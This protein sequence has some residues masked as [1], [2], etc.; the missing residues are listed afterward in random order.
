MER[1]AIEYQTFLFVALLYDVQRLLKQSVLRGIGGERENSQALSD[2][3]PSLI[4][5]FPQII[6]SSLILSLF[7]GLD[8][9]PH[10]VGGPGP[11]HVYDSHLRPLSYLIDKADTLSSSEGN[12]GGREHEAGNLT[13]LASVLE[14]V[15]RVGYEER[16]QGQHRAA[17]L[18]LPADIEKMFPVEFTQYEREELRSHLTVMQMTCAVYL[19]PKWLTALIKTSLTV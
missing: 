11:G 15:N 18:G 6:D 14:R 4:K 3:I 10:S 17:P 9:S 13:P 5:S 16:L 19:T 7:Q 2:F 1:K 12:S 8:E